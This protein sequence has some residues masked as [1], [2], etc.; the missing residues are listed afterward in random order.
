MSWALGLGVEG[1]EVYR[2][3]GVVSRAAAFT[4]LTDLW[5]GPPA[6][7]LRVLDAVVGWSEGR[8]DEGA[9]AAA[10]REIRACEPGAI[11][12]PFAG[13]GSTLIAALL[14]G[15]W[16]VGVEMDA[17]ICELAVRRI[18]EVEAQGPLPSF[19]PPPAP[20]QQASL[21]LEG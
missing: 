1:E 20:A 10:L 2:F 8:V 16:S 6:A 11:L 9:V 3:T 19:R 12:D 4:L 7:A 15:R 18:R 5:P 17:G 21:P 14:E 13:G